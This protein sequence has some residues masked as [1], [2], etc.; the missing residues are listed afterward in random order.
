M[1][2]VVVPPYSNAWRRFPV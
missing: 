2:S 1:M